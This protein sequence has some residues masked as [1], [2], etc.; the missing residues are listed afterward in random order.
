MA[1]RA[2]SR[3]FH[4]RQPMCTSKPI[5]EFEELPFWFNISDYVENLFQAESLEY[6]YVVKEGKVGV[7]YWTIEKHT[8]SEKIF[9]EE[10]FHVNTIIS[11]K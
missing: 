11:K 10:L 6:L 7:L 2:G 9:L 5:S 1:N 4:I 3:A 8:Y